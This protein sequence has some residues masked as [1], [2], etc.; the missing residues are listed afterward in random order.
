MR[1]SYSSGTTLQ[2]E[3]DT[4]LRQKKYDVCI[5]SSIFFHLSFERETDL[6]RDSLPSRIFRRLALICPSVAALFPAPGLAA[7]LPVTSYR[8]PDQF[9]SLRSHSK[10][11]GEN[12]VSAHEQTFLE[13]QREALPL[14]LE[15]SQRASIG[16][17]PGPQNKHSCVEYFP[18]SSVHLRGI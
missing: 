13:V 11:I 15:A 5:H 17:G 7:S 10:A 6:L 16:P 12:L 9:L 3:E 8:H 14:Y 1:R 2:A 18:H 4:W